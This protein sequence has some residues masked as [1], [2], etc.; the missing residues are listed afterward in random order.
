M[1]RKK[2]LMSCFGHLVT[3]PLGFKAYSRGFQEL[4]QSKMWNGRKQHCE[5]ILSLNMSILGR[6]TYPCQGDVQL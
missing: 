1:A 6:S 4:Y 5:W 2:R 3:Y